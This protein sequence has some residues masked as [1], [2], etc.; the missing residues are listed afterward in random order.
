M[1][2]RSRREQLGGI[3]GY[4]PRGFE[5]TKAR[6]DLRALLESDESF[7][8]Y[9]Y[10]RRTHQRDIR[11]LIEPKNTI[12]VEGGLALCDLLYGLEDVH[13]FLESGRETQYRLRLRREQREFGYSP[14]Q[15]A[16]R[17]E[18]YYRDYRTFIHPQMRVADIVVR[19]DRDYRLTL[20]MDRFSPSPLAPDAM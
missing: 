7:V 13:I 15:I 1:L 5:L 19:V 17:F 9:Q 11:E 20:V 16:E 4:N 3:T 6:S 10:N 14:I 18:K 8:L 12:V 2:E